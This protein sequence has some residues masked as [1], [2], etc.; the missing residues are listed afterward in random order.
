[1][2]TDRRDLAD[3]VKARKILS[4]HLAGIAGDAEEVRDESGN[5]LYR[6]GNVSGKVLDKEALARDYPELN[7]D[8]YKVKVP[9]SH[10][11]LW[12]PGQKD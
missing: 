9:V 6:W 10:R 4:N 2:I 5:L 3:A 8:A 7:L 11:A 12:V 1:M